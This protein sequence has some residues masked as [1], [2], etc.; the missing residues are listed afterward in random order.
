[1][2]EEEKKRKKRKKRRPRNQIPKGLLEEYPYAKD[3]DLSK[4]YKVNAHT[5]KSWAHRFHIRKSKEF[6]SRQRST[7]RKRSLLSKEELERFLSLA[8]TRTNEQ[9]AQMFGPCRALEVCDILANKFNINA[10]ISAHKYSTNLR[11]A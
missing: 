9:L 2:A 5:I 1:M 4:K 6:V 3:A 8:P 11:D 10:R 7:G